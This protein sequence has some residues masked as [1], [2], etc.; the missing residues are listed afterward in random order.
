MSE[1]PQGFNREA[2]ESVCFNDW[3]DRGEIARGA[4]PNSIQ[5]EPIGSALT[6]EQ[7]VP[8]LSMREL[9]MRKPPKR[10]ER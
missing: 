8:G 2:G 5:P 7:L 9:Q 6:R 4:S 3:L 1:E 10:E